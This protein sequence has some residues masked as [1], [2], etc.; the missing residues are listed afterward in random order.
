MNLDFGFLIPL[1]ALVT[2]LIV[3]VLALR[4][5]AK[6]EQRRDDPD[7]PK[8]TLAVDAPSTRDGGAVDYD[9]TH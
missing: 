1:L 5:K 2:L 7:A 9:K 8:S 3:A 4:S 6:V